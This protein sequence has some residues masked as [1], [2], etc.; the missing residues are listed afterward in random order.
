MYIYALKQMC[1]Y[2]SVRI[3]KRVKNLHWTLIN[4]VDIAFPSFVALLALQNGSTSELL[5]HF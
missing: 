5:I 3:W 4:I 2:S 1:K